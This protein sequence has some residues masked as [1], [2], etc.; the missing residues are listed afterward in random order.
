MMDVEKVK[1]RRIIMMAGAAQ[2]WADQSVVVREGAT[3]IEYR[4]VHCPSSSRT[5]VPSKFSRSLIARRYKARES[6]EIVYN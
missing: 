1:R 3:A 2:I 4:Q 6:G 5:L